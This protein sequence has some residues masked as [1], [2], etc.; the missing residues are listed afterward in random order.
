MDFSTEVTDW[1]LLYAASYNAGVKLVVGVIVAVGLLLLA[2]ATNIVAVGLNTLKL[3]S[4]ILRVL[5][6]D[7]SNYADNNLT[8]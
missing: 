5:S 1:G 2:V 6:V 8:F 7:E 3:N 4:G